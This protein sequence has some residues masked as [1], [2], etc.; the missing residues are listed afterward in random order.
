MMGDLKSVWVGGMHWNPQPRGLYGLFVAVLALFKPPLPH[1]LPGSV[2]D[3]FL[4]VESW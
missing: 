3:G 2:R 1:W 4:T